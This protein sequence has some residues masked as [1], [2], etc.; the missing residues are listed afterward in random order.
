[1]YLLAVPAPYARNLLRNLKNSQ[2]LFYECILSSKGKG[3]G[4]VSG[5]FSIHTLEMGKAGEDKQ[6]NTPFRPLYR[7]AA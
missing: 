5:Y 7:M 4:G 3:R 6:G 2:E 1:M